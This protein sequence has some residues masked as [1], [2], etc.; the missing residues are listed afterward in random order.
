MPVLKNSRWELFAQGLA[1]GKTAGE[2]YVLAGYREN[3]GNA[4]RLK[5]NEQII[6]RIAEIQAPAAKRIEISIERIVERFGN[7]GMCNITDGVKVKKGKVYV[8]DTDGLPREFTDA[9]A[10]FRPTK[11]GIEVKFHD[12]LT[13]L[14]LLGKHKGMFKENINLSVEVS[15][16]DLVNASYSKAED[17]PKD[18]G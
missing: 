10:G 18:K 5:Q 12:P 13:A 14:N 8:E 1:Q 16:S 3:P 9:I 17:K 6:G 4:G 15:L 2:A 7:I 11:D